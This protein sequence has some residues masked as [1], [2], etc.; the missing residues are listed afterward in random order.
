MIRHHDYLCKYGLKWPFFLFS[1]LK[2]IISFNIKNL[3]LYIEQDS[4][5]KLKGVIYGMACNWWHIS[6]S[7][8]F[9]SVKIFK[10]NWF[11]LWNG[12]SCVLRTSI[13]AILLQIQMLLYCVKVINWL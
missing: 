8:L 4:F 10:I 6:T 12:N 5:N 2:E 13:G 1:V 9:K 7:V 11:W 3:K